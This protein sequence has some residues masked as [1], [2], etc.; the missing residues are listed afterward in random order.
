M[1]RVRQAPGGRSKKVR[2]TVVIGVAGLLLLVTGP[3]WSR[4][5]NRPAQRFGADTSVDADK[6]L[7]NAANLAQDRQWSE[8]LNI[9]Q[10]GYREIRREGRPVAQAR[11]RS[12]CRG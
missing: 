6:L 1:G 2:W 3:G 4:A 9:Y 11:G 8:A 12:R 10:R 5:Q 7:M